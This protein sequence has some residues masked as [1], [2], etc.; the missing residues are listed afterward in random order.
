VLAVTIAQ[1]PELSP[2]LAI[3]GAFGKDGLPESPCVRVIAALGI[4]H[5]QVAAGEV[6]V[7]SLV[8]AAKLVGALERQKE[9][10]ASLGFG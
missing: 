4:E 10:S 1:E 6:T 5:G 8:N 2:R 7:D 3:T 9:P